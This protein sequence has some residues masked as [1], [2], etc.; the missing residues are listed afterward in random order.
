MHKL[1]FTHTKELGSS[2]HPKTVVSKFFV[3]VATKFRS[4]LWGAVIS[5]PPSNISP[6]LLYPPLLSIYPFPLTLI[7]PPLPTK[8][9]TCTQRLLSTFIR[10]TPTHPKYTYTPKTHLHTQNTPTHQKYKKY[11]H[12]PKIHL[13]NQNTKNTPTHPKHTYTPSHPKYT[14]T[15]K[16]H[17]HT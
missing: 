14:N 15:P 10:Y 2:S 6:P 11:T 4:V 13:Y 16:I 17:L 3:S 8:P 9:V 5:P 12:T 1:S 7:S